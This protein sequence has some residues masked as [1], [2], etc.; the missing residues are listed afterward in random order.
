MNEMKNYGLILPE[1]IETREEGA[2]HVLGSAGLPEPVILPDGNHLPYLVD[3][4]PQRKEFDTFMCTI[5]AILTAIEQAIYRMT[6]VKVNYAD[7]YVGIVA[8]NRGVLKVGVGAN[9][10]DMLELIRKITGQLAEGKCPWT[11]DLD[12]PDKYFGIAGQELANLMFDGYK[13]YDEWTLNHKWVFTSGT[14]QEKRAKLQDALTKGEVVVSVV[15]WI[16]DSV[17]GFYIK[18]DGSTDGHLTGLVRA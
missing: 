14:P 4:E 15:A 5:Y 2:D 18:P 8:K 7:R 10:H 9:P 1:K 17:K 13:W 12:T 6:G 16:F 3:R 11:D